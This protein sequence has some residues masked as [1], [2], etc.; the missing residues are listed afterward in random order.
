VS[1]PTLNGIVHGNA[2]TFGGKTHLIKLEKLNE[3][4]IRVVSPVYRRVIPGT[5]VADGTRLMRCVFPP[6]V[7]A[8]FSRHV[9]EH[10]NH[11]KLNMDIPC[12]YV[13]AIDNL[14]IPSFDCCAHIC[15]T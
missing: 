3:K 4:G 12:V 8:F 14:S 2:T 15:N 9:L 7:V 6:N 10:R 13:Q 1:F 5:Q 11:C